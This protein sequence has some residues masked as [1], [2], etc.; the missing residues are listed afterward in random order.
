MPQR[1]SVEQKLEY[2]VFD[3]L[4][5]GRDREGDP[6]E[7]DAIDSLGLEQLVDY[8]EHEFGV[9]ISDEEM[10][11]ENFASVA[12]LAAFIDSKLVEKAR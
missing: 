1:R 6:L 8:I 4:F 10:V 3:E 12:T 2:F 7:A 5:D 11:K 9:T